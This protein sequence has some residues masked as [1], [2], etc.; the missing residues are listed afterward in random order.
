MKTPKPSIW[1]LLGARA[2]DNAQAMELGRR[3]GGPV[4]TRQLAFNTRSNLPNWM[5]GPGFFGLTSS[6][7]EA[8][9]PPWPDIAIGAG[10]RSAPVNLAIRQRSQGKTL[11]IHI[12]RPRMDAA[13]F[14]MVLTTPQYGLPGG[15]N[16]VMLDFPFAVARD[17]PPQTLAAFD[18]MWSH[19]PR[20]WIVGVIG[21]AKFP[22]RFG[23]RDIEAFAQGL[24]DLARRMKGS[25]ILMDSPRSLPGAIDLV[26]AGIT[27]PNWVWTRGHGDNPYQSALRLGDAFAVTSDSVSMVAE[28]V[29]TGRP[30]YVHRLPVSSFVPSWQAQQ[31]LGARLAR[32]G[33]LSP[34]RSVAAYVERLSVKG[35]VGDLQSGTP[36]RLS[37]VPSDEHDVAVQRILTLWNGRA[38]G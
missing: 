4:V 5:T 20:P 12:G 16:V 1:V 37:F 33:I 15:S 32:R 18:A 8:L 11:A 7:A 2:G 28:M 3:L 6:S 35:W 30:T 26:A 13:R 29:Q 38:T 23:V 34:P 9:V 27:V 19:F 24:N 10:R 25:V 21:A 36:P 14:D 17:V 22:I 31:G